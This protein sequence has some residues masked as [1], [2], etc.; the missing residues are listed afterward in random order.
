MFVAR[1]GERA[2]IE[3]GCTITNVLTEPKGGKMKRF[4]TVLSIPFILCAGFWITARGTAAQAQDDP[5]W[6][7]DTYNSNNLEPDS[8]FKADILVVVAH[9]DDESMIAA[10]LAREVYDHGKRVAVVY[11]TRGNAGDNSVGPEQGA[12]LANIREIEGRTALASLGI[13]NVWFLSGSDTPSQNVLQSLGSWGHGQCLEQLVRIVRLTRPEVMISLLPGFVTGENHGDHQ[14]AGVLATEAFDL[15]GDPTVFA[16]QVT[17]AHDLELYPNRTEALRPWQP[18]K[19]YYFDNPTQRFDAGWG[20][21]YST[22]EISPTRH[23]SYGMLALQGFTY[24]QTQGGKDTAMEMASGKSDDSAT[25]PVQLIMG[26][27]LVK[28]GVTD[29]VFTGVTAEAL[30]YQPPPGFVASTSAN[31]TLKIG[32]AWNYYRQFWKS[33]GLDRLENLVPVEITV[34][35]GGPLK[36]PLLVENP[37]DH[38]IELKLTVQ[39]PEGWKVRP[40]HPVSVPA[41]A[42]Y[43]LQVMTIAPPTKLTGW[44]E[45]T[46]S[47]EAENRNI[48]TVHLR[49]EVDSWAFEN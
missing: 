3:S 15:A 18:Q 47:G 12:S 44:Q 19:I 49:A 17:P 43:Y 10:F 37:L 39:S 25:A 26:K 41:H 9:P 24:H 1:S 45:F 36:I 5:G 16:E 42:T 34:R 27:S 14:A 32:G 22:Q 40:T 33:H 21:E 13:A 30:P 6:Q 2:L 28:S 8:R 29:D 38:A 31:P 20:P 23:V 11:A 4:G 48:G 7:P 35:A 46:V